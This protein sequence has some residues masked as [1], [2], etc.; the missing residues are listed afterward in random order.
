MEITEQGQILYKAMIEQLTYVK[1]Q[2]WTITNYLMLIYAAIFW[3]AKNSDKLYAGEQCILSS[4]TILAGA[5]VALISIVQYDLRDAR[6]RIKETEK[7]IFDP[8][9]RAAFQTERHQGLHPRGLAFLVTL[10]SVC[11]LGAGLL[12]WFL[13]RV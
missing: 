13:W 1:R 4:L 3:L 9:E 2:Q 12:I 5:S 10:I 11:V 6:D 7:A 8:P